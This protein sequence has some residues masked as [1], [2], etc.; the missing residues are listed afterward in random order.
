M[1]RKNIG[2][3]LAAAAAYGIFR[4]SKMTPE[5]K[6]SLMTKG[7]DLLNKNLGS[8]K[9]TVNKANSAVSERGY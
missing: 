3:L 5:Q 2:L 8:L 9:N 1:G 6:N 7:K 4:Y